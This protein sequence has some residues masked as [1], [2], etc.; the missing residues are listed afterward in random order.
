[1]R[2][3]SWSWVVLLLAM[4]DSGWAGEAQWVEVKSPH[5]SVV[6]DAGEKRGHEV[7]VRFEQMRAVFGSLLVKTNVNL[8][9]PLQIIAF[10]NTKEMRQ[11]APLF[12]GKPIELAG[13]FQ[14]S[15][16]RS[17]ILLDMSTEDPWQVVFHEYAH[18]LLNGNTSGQVQPWFDEGFAE[19]FSTI[20]V[21]GK[22]ADVGLPPAGDVE[23]L[24]HF[25]WLRIAD[26][27]Q[28]QQNSST[29]N[30]SGDHRSVFYAESWLVMHFLYDKGLLVKAAP[31][32][33]LAVDQKVPVGKAVRQAF[34]MTPEVWDKQ[35]RDYY[36]GDTIKYYKLPTPPG[37]ETTGYTT[38]PLSFADSKAVLADMHLH[39]PDYQEKAIQEFE[40]VL[41]VEP[42][43]AAALR[44]LGYAY[45]RKHQLDTAADYF[46]KAAAANGKDPRV[47]YYSAVLRNQQRFDGDPQQIELTQKELESSIAL[48]PNF[49]DAYS[50][51][52]FVF[53]SQGKFD[54]AQKAMLHA[55]ALN[56]R[57]ENYQYNL[58]QIYLANR[59]VDAATAILQKLKNSTASPQIAMMAASSLSQ[60][61]EYKAA[62][63][64]KPADGFAIALRARGQGSDAP[65]EEPEARPPAHVAAAEFLK[66]K[67][68][69]VDCSSPPAAVLTISA[70]GKAWKMR[71]QD[72]G[73]LILIGA[74]EL[75]CDLKNRSVAV[76]YRETGT[77][78]GDIISL[79]LQ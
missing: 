33:D 29:Y 17:F 4:V 75:S 59:S 70:G 48:D 56:P 18:Q 1:M 55:V 74:D 12:H 58:A 15:D 50:V 19:Y 76:N 14:Y 49:A 26:L 13:L 43:N 6:T 67:V 41:T 24:R 42:N 61:D 5:F 57:N 45:L 60:V 66:G 68:T 53:Q 40:E 16:D 9:V 38:S 64:A 8:A 51:L 21:S 69:A 20:K 22:E 37:I 2:R 3:L 46:Q 44:G 77:E 72:R 34:G 62:Q 79:E 36:N 35:L 63:E 78:Q 30:E 65:N 71:A 10:R 11:F 32:F 54:D 31:Y 73:H 47:L 27:F 39:S 7:A 25:S 28:V 52:A 23:I